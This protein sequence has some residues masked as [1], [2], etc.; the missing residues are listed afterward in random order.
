MR[1][2]KCIDECRHL[3]IE[4]FHIMQKD[5]LIFTGL[6]LWRNGQCTVVKAQQH[7]TINKKHPDQ[8]EN[9]AERRSRSGHGGQLTAAIGSR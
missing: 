6:K 2:Q 1:R 4:F 7:I 8:Q 5:S 3:T 9:S